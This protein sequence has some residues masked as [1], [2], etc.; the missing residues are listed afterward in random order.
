VSIYVSPFALPTAVAFNQVRAILSA[1]A[2]VAG[3]GSMTIQD[4]YGLYTRT[5]STLSLATQFQWN[6]VVSQNSTTAATISW[7]AGSFNS[8]SVAGNTSR[9]SGNVT[10]SMTGLRQIDLAYTSASQSLPAGQYYIAHVHIDRSSSLAVR[11]ANSVWRY[12]VSQFTGAFGFSNTTGPFYCNFNGIASTTTNGSLLNQFAL[13]QAIQV[14]AI[15]QTGGTTLNQWP[16]LAF[17]T[18]TA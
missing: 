7:W 13:P 9:V 4:I 14:S 6:A 3:T 5:G 18:V 16:L 8:S 1:G 10:A 2:T 15:T 12:S 11:P 17:A